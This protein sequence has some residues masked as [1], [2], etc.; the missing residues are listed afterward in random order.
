M[1][2]DAASG[3]PPEL[4]DTRTAYIYQPARTATQSGLLHDHRTW[5][6][7]FDRA[8]PRWENPLM[9]WTSSRD[10]VQGV[11]LSFRTAEEAARFAARQGWR[12]HVLAPKTSAWR[13]KTYADNFVYSVARLKFIRT[14]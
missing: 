13:R 1:R 10:A 11:A 9:G 6:I 5:R 8:Q 12:S 14:K 4:A 7:D 2:V 3:I